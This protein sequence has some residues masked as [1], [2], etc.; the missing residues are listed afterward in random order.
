MRDKEHYGLSSY[1]KHFTQDRSAMVYLNVQE[2]E[3]VDKCSEKY[4]AISEFISSIQKL[5]FW[6][7][8]CGE[9]YQNVLD[10]FIRV[11]AELRSDRFVSVNRDFEDLTS[12]LNR[13]FSAFKMLAGNNQSLC[14]ARDHLIHGLS[15]GQTI[16]KS[17]ADEPS[18]DDIVWYLETA[19]EMRELQ[20]AYVVEVKKITD[21]FRALQRVAVCIDLALYHFDLL[22]SLSPCDSVK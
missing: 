9:C 15:A 7:D 1:L 11:F 21:V 13:I 16:W 4:P 10:V 20:E 12:E 14:D 19:R 6:E 5:K 2:I 8:A 3:M 22:D 17:R 18:Q